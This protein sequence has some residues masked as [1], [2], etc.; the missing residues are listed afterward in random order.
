MRLSSK[1]WRWL[2][3]ALGLLL[4]AFFVVRTWVVPA[5]IVNQIRARYQGKVVVGDW[6][7]GLHSAGITGVTLGE[8]S[9][10]DSPAWFSADRIS[11]DLSLAGLIRGRTKPTRVEIDRP[12]I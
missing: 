10:D 8:T 11:T 3:I 9:S 7:L 5:V 2:G 4:V 12:R 6:W 1:K